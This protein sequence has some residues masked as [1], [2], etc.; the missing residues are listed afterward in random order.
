MTAFWKGALRGAVVCGIV[1][2][3]GPFLLWRLLH[4][5]WVDP[6][7]AY[8]WFREI[9]FRAGPEPPALSVLPA[10]IGAIVGAGL[11]GLLAFINTMRDP[12]ATAAYLDASSDHSPPSTGGK[13]NRP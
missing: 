4:S 5:S 11:G 1:G 8:A 7:S 2:L 3:F 6:G 12:S 9:G 10:L 13:A